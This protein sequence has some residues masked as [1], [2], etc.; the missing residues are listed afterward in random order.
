MDLGFS[1]EVV[2]FYHKYRRGYPVGVFDVLA[3][4]LNLTEDDIAVD[5][6]CGTG[7]I[8]VPLAARIGAVVGMDPS[9]DMLARARQEAAAQG[10]K[11][12][13]WV[14]G[15]DSDLPQLA[16]ILGTGRPATEATVT[17]EAAVAAV[18]VGQALHWIDHEALFRAVKPML[19]DGGGIAILTNGTPL[20]LQP[21]S[22]SEALK[23]TLER[24]LDTTISY[25]CG[26]DEEAQDRYARALRDQ[27]YEVTRESIDYD[28][29]LTLDQVIGG[30]FSAISV[31]KVSRPNQRKIL[32]NNIRRAIA[33]HAPFRE[34]VHVAI[35]I[36]KLRG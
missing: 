36:G 6:G 25:A 30:V 21:T 11:N 9:A 2:D 14:L 16:A 32:A 34:H 19:R 20:W 12:I 7:Q 35:I 31:D 26:T 13:G 27:G 15:A 1:G 28:D 22:W 10:A 18:T 4:T 33:P 3:R 17:T 8:T 5:L 23:S 24:C 29:D